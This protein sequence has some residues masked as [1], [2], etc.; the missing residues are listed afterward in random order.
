M[1]M[2]LNKRADGTEQMHVKMKAYIY[3]FMTRPAFNFLLSFDRDICNYG[4][5]NV[6]Q[7]LS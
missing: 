2:S 4:I 1:S 5:E 7:E 6:L 3:I